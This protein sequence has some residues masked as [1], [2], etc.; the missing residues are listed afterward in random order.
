MSS[1]S[2]AISVQNNE[3]EKRR[4]VLQMSVLSTNPRIGVC[5]LTSTES[6]FLLHGVLLLVANPW[7]KLY[8]GTLS[9]YAL[10]YTFWQPL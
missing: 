5:F 10:N 8:N 7:L 2:Q 6:L 9:D 1:T 4:F 3:E